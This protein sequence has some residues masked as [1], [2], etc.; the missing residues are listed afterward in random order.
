MPA[1]KATPRKLEV[2][3]KLIAA[4]DLTMAEIAS[5]VNLSVAAIYHHIPA[6]RTRL[7][8][9]R[10]NPPWVDEAKKL[11]NEGELTIQEIANKLEIHVSNIYKRLPAARRNSL[12]N[13]SR[14]KQ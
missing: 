8:P 9:K 7:A 12:R 6:A 14:R 2:I 11:L 3:R 13:R 10:E 1:R 4:G 5:K